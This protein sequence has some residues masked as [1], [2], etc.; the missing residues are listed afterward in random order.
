MT[1]PSKHATAEEVYIHVASEIEGIQ[2]FL[3]SSEYT[4]LSAEI[5]EL[6]GKRIHTDR[7]DAEVNFC[8]KARSSA[9]LSIADLNAL[10]KQEYG[11][12]KDFCIKYFHSERLPN[13]G[14]E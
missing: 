11:E 14:Q 5:I 3:V 6:T 10:S 13:S 1:S 12:L 9:K 4:A 7:Y 2:K 8:E